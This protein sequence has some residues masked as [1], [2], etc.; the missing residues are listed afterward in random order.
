M[1]KKIGANITQLQTFAVLIFFKFESKLD[2]NL[3]KKLFTLFSNLILIF[4]LKL[5]LMQ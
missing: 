4:H 5:T 2:Y 1:S 3:K